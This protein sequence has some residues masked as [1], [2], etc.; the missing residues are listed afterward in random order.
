MF[1]SPRELFRKAEEKKVAIGAFNTNNL[2]ITQ[3]IVGAAESLNLPAIIQTTP[4]AIAYAG[5]KELFA[6]V[7]IA[8]DQAKA[9]ITID[10]DHCRDF[11]LL[12][13]CLE[14]GYKSVMFDGSHLPFEEN[15][16]ATKKAVDLAQRFEAFVE[17][18]IGRISKGEEGI[19]D[20]SG[21]FTDPDEAADFAKLTG[22]NSLAISIGNVHG[23]PSGEKL[24]L[25]LLKEIN[26]KV[27]IPLVL[28]GASGLGRGD[29]RQAIEFGVR[30]INID[31]QIR[32]AF[33]VGLQENIDDPNKD[34]RDYLSD[35]KEDVE[36]VVER[37][38]KIFNNI[39]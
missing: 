30:K 14:C 36:Q 29:L 28:H 2:E 18:E 5:L 17:G 15:V 13:K 22:V 31:T 7:K 19:K 4:K 8:I 20:G 10:L 6:I 39:E 32:R 27:D 11:D 21:D 24:N 25:N 3:A 33:K 34:I 37:Y 23:A 38:L 35:A 26:E 1:I 12:K 16:A 9:P